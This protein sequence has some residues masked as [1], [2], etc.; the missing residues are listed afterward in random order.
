[1]ATSWR[2]TGRN[3]R[4]ECGSKLPNCGILIRRMSSMRLIEQALGL[5]EK[6]HDR[7]DL[8]DTLSP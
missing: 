2:S 7:Y 6:D 8:F 3:S 5:D 4:A 1:M